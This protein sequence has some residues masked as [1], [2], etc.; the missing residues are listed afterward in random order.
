MQTHKNIASNLSRQLPTNNGRESFTI[1]VLTRYETFEEASATFD[2]SEQISHVASDALHRPDIGI[3]VAREVEQLEGED[4]EIEREDIVSEQTEMKDSSNVLFEDE[5]MADRFS[6]NTGVDVSP[7]GEPQ[8]EIQLPKGDTSAASVVALTL[9]DHDDVAQELDFSGNGLSEDAPQVSQIVIPNF[10]P[11]LADSF[12]GMGRASDSELGKVGKVREEDLKREL[13]NLQKQI[14][15]I[16]SSNAAR[17]F[18]LTQV[19]SRLD[20]E[21]RHLAEMDTLCQEKIDLLDRNVFNLT[22]CLEMSEASCEE[23][24]FYLLKE[25]SRSG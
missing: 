4:L 13:D 2:E 18:E 3:G 17:R 9:T 25:Q 14:S 1:F 10:I 11:A 24:E 6:G 20:R 16:D 8:I 22:D 7:T 15:A 19:K 21:R 12:P 5:F 23:I